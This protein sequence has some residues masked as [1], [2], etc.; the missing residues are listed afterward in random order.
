MLHS[1]NQGSI[2]HVGQDKK[3]FSCFRYIR[4]QAFV[5]MTPGAGPL[6]GPRGKRGK[7]LLDHVRFAMD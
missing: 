5:N 1:N 7:G 4:L 6:F 2:G 3:M